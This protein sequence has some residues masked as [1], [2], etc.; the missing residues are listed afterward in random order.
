MLDQSRRQAWAMLLCALSVLV[1]AALQIVPAFGMLGSG[2]TLA[3]GTEAERAER[4]AA[5]LGLPRPDVVFAVSADPGAA[6]ASTAR[7]AAADRR[8]ASLLA[9]TPGVD[10]VASFAGSGDP[11]LRSRDGRTLLVTADLAG[12]ERRRGRTAERIAPEVRAA[13]APATLEISGSAWLTAQIDAQCERDLLRAELL[14]AP[15]VLL[16]LLVAYG[17]LVCAL[18]PVLVAACAVVCTIPVLGRLARVTD[19]SVFAVNAASAIGFGLAVDYT[20]FLLSRYQEETAYGAT[21]VRALRTA[22]RTSGRSVVFSAA[23]V[24]ACLAATLVVPSPLLR[25]LALAGIVVTVL[26]A[27]AALFLL[28]SLLTLLGPH[29]HRG[30]PL[31]GLRRCRLGE[32]SGFWQSVTRRVTAR[33]LLSGAAAGVVL[34]VLALP[35]SRVHLGVIDQRVLPASAPAAAAVAHLEAGFDHPPDRLLSVVADLPPASGDARRARER[36]AS[37]LRAL[38]GVAGVRTVP[39]PTA[40]AT[41]S[42]Q[43]VFVVAARHAPG[44]ERAA[45]LVRAVRQ[46]PGVALVGGRAA[47]ITDTVAAVCAALPRVGCLLAAVFVVLLVLLTRSLVAPVKALVVAVLSLG[48]SA[49]ALVLVFQLGHGRSL[50]AGFSVTGALDASLLLFTLAIALALSVDYEVFLLGRL[51]EEHDRTGDNTFA[52]VRGIARTGRLMTSAAAAVAVSTVALVTS[53]VSSLK[54]VGVGVAVA[55]LVDALLVRGVLVP[56][57][58]AALGPANWWAPALRRTR[59]SGATRPQPDGLRPEA[60]HPLAVTEGQ[61]K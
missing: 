15:A 10:A 30:D 48:A 2:G 11:W 9:H 53:R 7:L 41:R 1:I 59:P 24:T 14:A 61:G 52:I 45:R 17:S 38:P 57:V 50:V 29:L 27:L 49:G 6:A 25:A 20:L 5:R 3:T 51:R 47:E 23:A 55:A 12:D 4:R 46:V 60:D 31:R 28:P 39:T 44:G 35:F 8:I 34:L 13:A 18:L 26:S 21:P 54:L 16:V 37:R 19:V 33:P 56:A 42:A 36:Y 43:A 22:W 32:P 40:A 58:M